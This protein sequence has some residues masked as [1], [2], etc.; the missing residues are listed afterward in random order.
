MKAMLGD[1]FAGDAFHVAANRLARELRTRAT[2]RTDNHG[3]THKVELNLVDSIFVERTLMPEAPFLDLL[4]REYD[5]GVRQVDFKHAFEPARIEI[6]DWVAAE[7]KDRIKDL[8]PSDS[9]DESTRIVVVNALYF[10]GSWLA[11][12]AHEITTN[13][14][15]HAL[16][17]DVQVPTMHTKTTFDY[18][19]H[20]QFA[21]AELLYEGD[22]LRMTIVLPAPGM[23]ESVR[24]QV[25]SAW[26]EQA[27]TGVTPT[28][29]Q[30]AL[31]KFKLTVG[32]FSLKAALYELG[33]KSAFDATADFSGMFADGGLCIS[34]VLQKAFISVD[35]AGTEAAAATAVV[36]AP[37][38]AVT[39]AT[40]FIVDRPFLFFIR[41]ATGSVLFS[42]QVVDPSQ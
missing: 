36:L 13:A 41:D 27:V 40:P 14:A 8:L 22:A 15:F 26:L 19:S 39:N 4:A 31:P 18:A 10:Y 11:P 20:D 38:A 24:N 7:T 2:S 17:G 29:L 6:N 33:M 5:S 21:V 12:F 23:F 1:S 42:G 30:L 28:L 25:S 35:E 3:E 37:G 9:I 32:T 34:D 16:S